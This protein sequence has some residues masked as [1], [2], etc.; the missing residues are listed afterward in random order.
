MDDWHISGLA[1]WE[2]G[3]TRFSKHTIM[4]VF[5]HTRTSIRLGSSISV[6]KEHSEIPNTQRFCCIYAKLYLGASTQVTPFYESFSFLPVIVQ[7]GVQQS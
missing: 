7:T 4:Y 1:E 6:L 5:E 2:I 3:P